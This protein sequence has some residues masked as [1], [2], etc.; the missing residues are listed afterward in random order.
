MHRTLLL[1]GDVFL[2]RYCHSA[3][4]PYELFDTPGVNLEDA[5]LML[6]SEVQFLMDT[7][8]GDDVRIAFSDP[9]DNWRFRVLPTY[10]ASRNKPK[11]AGYFELREYARETY[12][13]RMVPTL[14]GDDVLGI[15]ATGKGIKGEKIIVSIDK[16]MK[17]LPGMWWD[18]L[19]P[20]RGIREFSRAEA[21][22]FHLLQ[23][24]MGDA[25]DEYKGIPGVGPKKAEKILDE[26][27]SWA[28]VVRAYESKGLTEE[29]ALQQARVAH[30]LRV[31]GFSPRKGV[32]LWRPTKRYCCYV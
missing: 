17:T 4:L 32:S 15:W 19:H 9:D 2:H 27:C 10:K 7:L 14:E 22:R 11:P 30:I 12:K 25:V 26:E 1:D 16:D 3:S 20:E 18:P 23:T 24:L 13:A 31:G 8:E 21:D 28:A 5:K 29:D 6:D